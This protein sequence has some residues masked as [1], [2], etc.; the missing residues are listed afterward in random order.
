VTDTIIEALAADSGE[1]VRPDLAARIL[2][3]GGWSMIWVGLLALGF[4]VH[5]VYVTTWLAQQEQGELTVERLA[6][7]RQRLI[8]FAEMVD[9]PNWDTIDRLTR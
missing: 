4:V 2:R 6:S 3:G 1:V 5:Q 9:G 7:A 8:V